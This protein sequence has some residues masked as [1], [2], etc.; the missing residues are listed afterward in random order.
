MVLTAMLQILL[1][2]VAFSLV[3]VGVLVLMSWSGWA[4]VATQFP[5]KDPAAGR[6]FLWGN[7][8]IFSK[9]GTY[10][11]TV[12]ITVSDHGLHLHPVLLLRLA[13]SA[14]F[15]P[16][17]AVTN[18]QEQRVLHRPSA[19]LFLVNRPRPIRIIGRSAP[20]VIATWARARS[21]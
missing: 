15:I 20:D 17:S 2:I 13:H 14:I 7:D 11:S 10:N 21:A 3:V 8:V 5:A 6:S 1:P 18:C 19:L 12:R 16:W 4:S 9:F